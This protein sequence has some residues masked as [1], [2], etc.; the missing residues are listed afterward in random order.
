MRRNRRV[1]AMALV[2]MV[3]SL[4]G[5]Y[6]SDFPLGSPEAGTIEPAI[7]GSWRCVQGAEKENKP[8]LIAIMPFD[9][10]QYYV[11]MDMEGE[12]AAHYRAFSS[13]VVG[14]TLLNVQ[15]M[16]PGTVPAGRKWIFVRTT[17]LKPNILQVELVRDGAFEGIGR[18]PSA[19]RENVEK[20]IAS[21]EL[22]QDFC[23]CTRVGEKKK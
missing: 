18:S 9:E 20:K 7:L 8:F 5:C 15:E 2:G 11:G 21:P 6:E 1:A 22:Y 10:K 12:K 16:D 19:V 23:V 3:L 13:A 4:W 14:T 17:L